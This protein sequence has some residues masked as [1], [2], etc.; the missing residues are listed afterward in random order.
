MAN[1]K[2]N[3]KKYRGFEARSIAMVESMAC[4]VVDEYDFIQ[5]SAIVKLAIGAKC[6]KCLATALDWD[7]VL[8]RFT[9][10]EVYP[11]SKTMD[12]FQGR[13]LESL[14]QVKATGE[15]GPIAAPLDVVIDLRCSNCQHTGS[16]NV[17]MDFTYVVGK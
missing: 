16:I 9:I 15:G 14:R 17:D 5:R 8:G 12:D 3:P 13:C 4:S 2:A 1:K 11:S 7:G 6:S 10:D